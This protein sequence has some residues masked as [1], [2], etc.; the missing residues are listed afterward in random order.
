MP[1]RTR[2]APAMRRRRSVP[3]VRRSP[4]SR[5]RRDCGSRLSAG[6]DGAQPS[7]IQRI[8]EIHNP[9]GTASSDFDGRRERFSGDALRALDEFDAAFGDDRDRL[10]GGCLELLMVSVL[11]HLDTKLTIL[12]TDIAIKVLRDHIALTVDAPAELFTSPSGR[13][14][15]E[16]F[17]ESA[18][19]VLEHACIHAAELGYERVLQP[20]CLLALLGETEGL[21]ERLIRLQLSPELGPAKV[22]AA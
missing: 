4:N 17:A 1:R 3:G 19:V 6:C 15:S 12:D 5:C 14:R 9:A 8:I 13:L 2:P 21:T 20:H 18:W 11:A 22:A 7:H 10:R 16:E